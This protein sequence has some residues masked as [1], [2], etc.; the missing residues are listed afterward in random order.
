MNLAL[1]NVQIYVLDI[2]EIFEY[3]IRQC[4]ICI[5]K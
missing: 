5:F 2:Y 1:S 4:L 3:L